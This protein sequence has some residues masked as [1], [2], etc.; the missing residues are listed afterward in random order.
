MYGV[1]NQAIEDYVTGAYGEDNWTLIRQRASVVDAFFVSMERYPDAVTYNL[2]VAAA[3]VLDID[4]GELLEAIGE[5]WVEFAKSHGYRAMFSLW[6][7]NLIEFLENLD[8]MHA[9]VK[10]AMPDFEPPHFRCERGGPDT[11]RLHY[12]SRRPG[13]APM[14]VGILRGLARH[15]DVVVHVDHVVVR[16]EEGGID[17]DEFDVRVEPACIREAVV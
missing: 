1:I 17:H 6:G 15:F 5:H 9:R 14:V 10:V 7:D 11:A 13:L 16:D 2:V 8:M 12:H 4:A 3:G